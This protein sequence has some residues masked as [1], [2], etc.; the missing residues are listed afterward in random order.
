LNENEKWITRYFENA[1]VAIILFQEDEMLACNQAARC[2]KAKLNFDPHYLYE[3]AQAAVDRQGRP[4]T[5]CPTCEI[6]KKTQ[7]VV[8]PVLAEGDES[9]DAGYLMFYKTLDDAAHITSLT[10][11]SCSSVNRGLRLAQHDEIN[12]VIVRA[13]EADRH[14]ISADL[15]DN[16]A[17]GLYFAMTGVNCLAN[18]ALSATERADQAAAITKQLQATLA[19]VKNM[20]LSVRP[21]VMDDFG[22]FAALRA[23]AT[24]LQ[25][26]TGIQISVSG[27]A[28]PEELSGEIQSAMY[29]VAQEA[30]NN[31]LKH[32]NAHEI[33]ILLVEHHHFITLQIIDDG[34]GFDVSQHTQ[35]N[36][37]SLGLSDMHDRIKALNGVFALISQP[38]AGTTVQ[39][40]FPVCTDKG[41]LQNV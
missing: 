20:A 16:I 5:D 25:A 18:D 24:R 37:H 29:R 38:G 2:L 31:A 12:R 13:N 15:H 7:E 9:V 27:N 10:L 36:G 28:L 8:V 6:A 22:L 26:T 40:K 32:A 35:F 3:I 14:Q 41:S 23:L 33:M 34:D 17:Q 1:P 21:S 39:V 19:E 4:V 30:I 11:K